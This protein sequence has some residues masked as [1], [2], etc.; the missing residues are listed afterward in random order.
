MTTVAEAQ[1][2]EEVT[3]DAI[4]AEL[5]R[6]GL[7]TPHQVAATFGRHPRFVRTLIERGDL[8]VT[9]TEPRG[10]RFVYLIDPFDALATML[11]RQRGPGR[12]KK[13]PA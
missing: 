8:R 11:G 6:G 9:R 2:E 13:N 7:L 5:A 4:I 1:R 12:P 10:T 3:R